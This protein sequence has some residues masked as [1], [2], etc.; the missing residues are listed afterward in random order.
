M[1]GFGGSIPLTAV[2]SIQCF[3][4]CDHWRII[5]V[6][7]YINGLAGSDPHVRSYEDAEPRWKRT[8]LLRDACTRMQ[9]LVGN[10]DASYGRY[11]VAK[12]EAYQISERIKSS[13]PTGIAGWCSHLAARGYV[14]A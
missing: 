12:H 4:S 2:R 11:F 10:A 13:L 1:G 9:S 14:M 5:L 7:S 6:S 8:M 3:F